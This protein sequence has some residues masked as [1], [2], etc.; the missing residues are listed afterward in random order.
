MQLT[1]EEAESLRQE[2]VEALEQ[3]R[4]AHALALFEKVVEAG[5]FDERSWLLLASC[6]RAE[7]DA[8]GEEAA[9]NR[10]LEL[11]PHSVRAHVFK[12]DCRARAGDTD[13]ACYFY[14]TA[15][16]LG[17]ARSLPQDELAEVQRAKSLLA[18]L[19]ERMHEVRQARLVARGLPPQQWS[20]RFRHSLEIA[21]GRRNAYLQRP[22]AYNFPELP[23][24][25]FYDPERFG[26]AKTV[27][28][29]AGSV[30]DE[31]V[32]LLGNGTEE[33]R[34]YIQSD[35][36]AIPLEANKALLNNKDW[37]VLGLCEQ[38]WVVPEVVTRC[39]R[40]WEAVLQAPLPRISGWGPTVVFSMLK[41]GA[42]IAPHT[43]MFNTRLI[44]HLPL[45]V[46]P[47]CRFRVGNEVREWEVGKLMIFDD[48]IEHEA[49][50]EG[51][52]DRVVLIFDIWRPELTDREMHELTAL[53]SD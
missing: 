4:S 20:P 18:E 9:L 15:L 38:G 6:R 11:D 10:L 34:P 49:W 17:S 36:S 53:F 51:D 8:A 32:A 45:I 23:Q 14:R 39:P 29:A 25:Q 12:G 31:L 16:Q 22:T 3:G 41:A 1:S 35:T 28:A 42:R 30:R 47:G 27:E 50:N 46:P 52:G 2:G 19:E 37:S 44:C 33:F 48:T 26:W 21:A 5:R 40:T 24:I 13:L 7:R 43:G